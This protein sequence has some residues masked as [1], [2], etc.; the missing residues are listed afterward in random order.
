MTGRRAWRL[1][2]A[3]LV[4]AA[5]LA[6]LA[7]FLAPLLWVA[8]M[9]F[10]TRLEIFA[11]PPTFLPSAP[12]LQ[13]YAS[14]F[15]PRSRFPGTIANSLIV[16]SIAT[17]V[18]LALGVCAAYALASRRLKQAEAASFWMLTFRMLPPVALVLPYY[19]VFRQANMLGSLWAI[20]LTHAVFSIA[21]VIWMMKAYFETLPREIEEAA[22][23]DGATSWQIFVRIALPLSHAAIAAA[24]I[25]S[26][27]TS[28]NEFL[29]AVILSRPQTQTVPVIVA[30]FVGEVYV[31][32][33]EL[34]AATMLGLL[35]ALALVFVSQ[36]YLLVGI[37]PGAVK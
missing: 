9:S 21:I 29:F 15:G 12:T 13:N 25:F 22:R 7:L 19:F 23:I 24:A 33:G 8:A 32:W 3:A 4:Y 30:S 2:S 36:R 6:V 17:G 35:P 31:S 20:G 5:A 37:A 18:A 27:L 16:A 28:W 14:L 26:F 34:A 11:W 10:K 1:V